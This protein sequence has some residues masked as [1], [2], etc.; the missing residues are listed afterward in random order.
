MYL[1]A[2]IGMMVMVAGLCGPAA[3]HAAQDE[4]TTAPDLK[5]D[6][7]SDLASDLSSQV[8]PKADVAAAPDGWGIF[9]PYF[10]GTTHSTKDMLAGVADI[11][12]GEEIHPPHRHAE[13]EFLLVTKGRGTWH[14][15]GK[16][17]PAKAGD[18]LYAA[19]WDIHGIK[20]TG[21]ENLEFVVWKWASK[22]VPAVEDPKKQ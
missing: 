6:L 21:S 22:G 19:P 5:S 8:K 13:E 10:T 3:A 1:R 20:N 18:M 9:Y 12:P 16:D 4:I 7:S 14:L 17:F 15:N 2:S 11:R